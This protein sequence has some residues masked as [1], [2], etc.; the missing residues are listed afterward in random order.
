MASTLK[1]TNDSPSFDFTIDNE[2]SENIICD[3]KCLW[4]MY[5][6]DRINVEM[7]DGATISSG[8]KGT[9]CVMLHEGIF[10]HVGDVNFVHIWK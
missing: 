3:R 7:A 9:I 5:N 6:A 8:E 4:Y 10:L 2:A 1:Y